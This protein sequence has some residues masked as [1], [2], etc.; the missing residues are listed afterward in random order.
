MD[1]VVFNCMPGGAELGGLPPSG[2]NQENNVA[3]GGEVGDGVGSN[4]GS[5]CVFSPVPS[6]T[7]TCDD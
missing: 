3:F 7:N 4:D 6:R 1:F 5:S 2:V